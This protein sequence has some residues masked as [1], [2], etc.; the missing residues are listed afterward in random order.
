MVVGGAGGARAKAPR[1][2]ARRRPAG[3]GRVG[4]VAHVV[5]PQAE[6]RGIH[7]DTHACPAHLA[8]LAA[9]VHR[10]EQLPIPLDL[11]LARRVREKADHQP[12]PRRLCADRAV[13]RDPKGGAVD[14]GGGGG[15][16][17]VTRAV[18]AKLELLLQADGVEIEA[19]G[20]VAEGKAHTLAT[21]RL[22]ASVAH[23]E[24]RLFRLCERAARGDSEIMARTKA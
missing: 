21:E 17:D 11:Q 4:D 1:P 15:R 19:L 3:Q 10:E 6:P 12:A 24:E 7:G 8:Q 2:H 13:G 20:D 16:R 9:E 22:V 23:V 5:I 18:L 14:A